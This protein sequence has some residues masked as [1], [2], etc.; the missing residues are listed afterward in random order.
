MV[1][2]H[3]SRPTFEKEIYEVEVSENTKMGSVIAHTKAV[4]NESKLLGSTPTFIYSL[5]GTV[6]T[7]SARK[8][9]VKLSA[10]S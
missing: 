9:K 2:N 3:W 10:V 1:Q 5:F 4:T 8:F 7:D 6:S